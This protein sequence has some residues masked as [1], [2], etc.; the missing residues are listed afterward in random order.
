MTIVILRIRVGQSGPNIETGLWCRMAGLT[1]HD[2]TDETVRLPVPSVRHRRDEKTLVLEP[3][4]DP[5]LV[6]G[7]MVVGF[8]EGVGPGEGPVP[9][10]RNF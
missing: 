1:K 7:G 3:R 9:L 8:R 4:P 5:G 6:N 10:P 2:G